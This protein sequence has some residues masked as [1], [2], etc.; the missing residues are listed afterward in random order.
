MATTDY[1]LTIVRPRHTRGISTSSLLW[2]LATLVSVCQSCRSPVY[3]LCWFVGLPARLFVQSAGR[4]IDNLS[5]RL[6]CHCVV[7]CLLL[8]LATQL[9]LLEL[10]WQCCSHPH[11]CCQ[12]V[13]EVCRC[14]HSGYC[15]NKKVKNAFRIMIMLVI[16]VV[17][18]ITCLL[19]AGNVNSFAIALLSVC[20]RV[21]VWAA[22]LSAKS[23]NYCFCS[24]L[25]VN[26]PTLL[27]CHAP[28]PSRDRCG[29]LSAQARQ[30]WSK[31][32]L[33]CAKPRRCRLLLVGCT[34]SCALAQMWQVCCSR[35][36]CFCRY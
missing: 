13:W 33:L 2:Q 29:A 14:Q 23:G 7:Q 8:Q 36:S 6:A 9:L 35:Y 3:F 20:A 15:C 16:I 32:S 25:I 11:Y 22:H 28:R 19:A 12:C 26:M 18:K 21:W 27:L 4:P 34:N 10:Q 5:S 31:S 30:T 1:R 17:G 24:D